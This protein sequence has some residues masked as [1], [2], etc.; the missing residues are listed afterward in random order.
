M[1]EYTRSEIAEMA[2]IGFDAL[3]YYERL[4]ILLPDRRS[5]ANYRLYG[6]EAVLKLAF[7][8]RA[9][10]CGFTLAEIARSMALIEST[11]PCST[12]PEREIDAK[13]AELDGRIADLEAMKASLRAV[14]ESVGRGDCAALRTYVEA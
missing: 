14:K 1:A 2:G 11:D 12:T 3:R 9:K 13:L 4:G 5:P 8:K 10:R 6:D 7:V